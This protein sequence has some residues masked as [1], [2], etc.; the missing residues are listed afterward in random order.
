MEIGLF[1]YKDTPFLYLDLREFSVDFASNINKIRNQKDI[2][3]WLNSETN[4]I[5]LYLIDGE[6]GIL[7]AQRMISINFLRKF[8]ILWN[9]KRNRRLMKQRK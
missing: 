5:Q 3:N 4:V 2:D 1:I 9:Y 7:K 6:T 8:E